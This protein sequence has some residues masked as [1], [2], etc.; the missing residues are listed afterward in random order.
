MAQR[1]H[2]NPPRE[3][4]DGAPGILTGAVGAIVDATLA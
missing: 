3:Q 1:S 2:R 4:A